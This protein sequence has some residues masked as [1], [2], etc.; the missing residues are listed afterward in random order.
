MVVLD[1]QQ[2][3]IGR[4]RQREHLCQLGEAQFPR[5]CLGFLV[6]QLVVQFPRQCLGNLG[7]R[8]CEEEP[9][10]VL[11]VVHAKAPPKLR[12]QISGQSLHQLLTV[13]RTSFALL[14][15][16]HYAAANLPIARRH[17]RIDAACRRL[18]RS[19]KQLHDAAVDAGVAGRQSGGCGSRR[20]RRLLD[21]AATSAGRCASVI[22]LR[23]FATSSAALRTGSS[24]VWT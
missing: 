24:S 7:D 9:P 20:R 17:Q 12:G 23:R 22:V 13:T 10:H 11:Q 4:P 3:H 6:G 8:V 16:L 21:H 19:A 2:P 14:L 1:H 5:H 18:A 15:G